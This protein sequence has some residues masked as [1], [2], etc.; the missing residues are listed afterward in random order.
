M[1]LQDAY[2][3]VPIHPESRWYLQFTM[4]GVPYQFRVLCFGLITAPQLFTRLMAP[5]S[6][7]VRRYGIRVLQY[8][9]D[10]WILTESRTTCIQPRKRLLHR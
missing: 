5:I 6:A 2:L 9:D 7:I 8:L 1:D 3:Q 10:W 4:A